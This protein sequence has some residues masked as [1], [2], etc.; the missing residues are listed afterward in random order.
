MSGEEKKY[1]LDDHANVKKVIITLFVVCG[2]LFI[3]DFFYH[4]H[5]YFASEDFFGFY[6]ILGAF[7]AYILSKVMPR[8]DICRV[9]SVVYG[10][11]NRFSF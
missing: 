10:L 8:V 2:L 7:L 1:W 9:G 3:A 5:S 4:K 11:R 6:A